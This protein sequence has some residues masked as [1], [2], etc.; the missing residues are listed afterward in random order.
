MSSIRWDRGAW[1]TLQ[2]GALNPAPA[3]SDMRPLAV[4][5]ARVIM[6]TE[7]RAQV[8]CFLIARRGALTSLLGK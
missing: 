2:G 5:S 3:H 7:S 6:I 8:V 4:C 1:S